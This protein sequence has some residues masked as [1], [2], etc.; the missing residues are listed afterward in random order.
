MN[1]LTKAIAFHLGYTQNF[2]IVDWKGNP[3]AILK[4]IC[5]ILGIKNPSQAVE[6]F[7]KDWKFTISLTYSEG[8]RKRAHKVLI[9]NEPGLLRLITRSDKPVA[10]ELQ[11]KIFSEII[12]AYR[13]RGLNWAALPKVWYF[14]G[15]MLNHIE[16]MSKKEAWY[17]KRFPDAD[18]D[19][20]L[21][22]LP[23]IPPPVP[24][25][26]EESTG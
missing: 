8:H 22:S 20:F 6:D 13:K 23:S 9:I 24:E 18:Y 4:D 21:R 16:W 19:D 10:R 17:F 5:K 15:Q 14:Q 7:P 11:D 3:W 26:A 25:K 1:E 12:P 2:H